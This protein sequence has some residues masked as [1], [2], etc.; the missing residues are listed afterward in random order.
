MI[1]NIMEDK[2][3]KLKQMKDLNN[4][5]EVTRGLFRFV[6]GTNSC[7]EIHITQ[8]KQKQD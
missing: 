4:W 6:I 1:E 8:R 7:Y 3:I 2:D 5:R